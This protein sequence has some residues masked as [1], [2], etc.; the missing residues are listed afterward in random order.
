MHL[1]AHVVREAP[2][3]VRKGIVTVP[4]QNSLV[5]S[6]CSGWVFHSQQVD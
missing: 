1:S 3:I 6:G 5:K 2:M 4:S